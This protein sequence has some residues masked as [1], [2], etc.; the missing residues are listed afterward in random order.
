VGFVLAL[1]VGLAANILKVSPIV[2]YLVAGICMGPFTPGF[3][4]AQALAK[5]D[6]QVNPEGT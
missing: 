1:L 4:R 6:P 5:R 3:G 2:G